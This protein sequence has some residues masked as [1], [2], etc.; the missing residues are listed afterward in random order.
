V[1]VF[2]KCIKTLDYIEEVI[3]SQTWAGFIPHLPDGSPSIG[4]WK[5]G[6]WKRNCEYSR[7][8]GQ[9]DANTRGELIN[10]FNTVEHSKLFLVSIEAGKKYCISDVLRCKF[11]FNRNC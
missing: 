4:G 7:I 6:G 9:V 5:I 3:Q 2:S 1:V 11:N 8:D 10:S